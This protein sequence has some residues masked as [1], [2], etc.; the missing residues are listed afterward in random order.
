MQPSMATN[1]TPQKKN[2]NHVDF[3]FDLPGAAVETGFLRETPSPTVHS[4]APRATTRI[5]QRDR[6]GLAR[7]TVSPG[8]VVGRT[9]SPPHYRLVRRI[10]VATL[11]AR[12]GGWTVTDTAVRW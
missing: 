12:E 2:L 9:G 10:L 4:I 3:I 7:W 5:G 6:V 1:N 8:P 11:T